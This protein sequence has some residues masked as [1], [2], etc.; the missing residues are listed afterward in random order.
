MNPPALVAN[1]DFSRAIQMSV[2]VLRHYH[3]IGLLEPVE[4]DR[5][6]GSRRDSTDQISMVQ[7]TLRIDNSKPPLSRTTECLC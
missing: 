4:V 7:I 1:G 5:C 6:T 2:K 3:Q